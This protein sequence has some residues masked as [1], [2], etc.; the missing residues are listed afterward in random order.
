MKLN[1]N[2]L[3][4]TKLLSGLSSDYDCFDNEFVMYINSV[5]LTLKQLGVGP[6][7]GFVITDKEATWDMFISDNDVLKESVKTYMGAKVRMKFDPPA[8]SSLA[9]AYENTIDE[10]EFRL[11]IEVDGSNTDSG[12]NSG[13]TTDYEQ[14]INLPSINGVTLKGNYDEKDPTV[15]SITPSDVDDIWDKE[16]KE[17]DE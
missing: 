4:S 1:D 14:L 12:G 5:F 6:S 16:F 3:I 2:I 7:S 13:G 9:K 8:Q 10:L 17:G 11:S 15:Q